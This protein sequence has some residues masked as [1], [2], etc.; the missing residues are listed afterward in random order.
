MKRNNEKLKIWIL[1]TGE[2]LPCDKNQRA[3]R[4]INLNNLLIAEKNKTLLISSNFNHSLKNFRIKMPLLSSHI[5]YKNL[6]LI[7]SIGY[8]KN[9]SL[10]RLLDHLVLSINLLRFLLFHSHKYFKPDLLFIGYPPIEWAFI[11]IIWAKFKKIKTILDIKDLWPDL[12]YSSQIGIKKKLIKLAC[13]QYTFMRNYIINNTLYISL[14]TK[15]YAYNWL[16]KI[17]QKDPKVIVSPLVPQA[18]KLKMENKITKSQILRKY[19]IKKDFDGITIIF[20]GSLMRTAYDFDNVLKSINI[21]NKSK[22]KLRLIIC[23]DGPIY[24]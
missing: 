4:A 18:D 12:F 3:M 15:Y 1:Q 9:I 13:I 19:N 16:K 14:P 23:G 21:F 8:A 24:K 7:N 6:I 17:R 22:V 11:S 20:F 5:K 2:P 10:A